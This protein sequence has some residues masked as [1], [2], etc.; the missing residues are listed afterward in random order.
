MTIKR[1]VCLLGGSAVGKTSLVTRFVRGAYDE[2]Y[3]TTVGV[4]I[5]T[6]AMKIDERS[7]NL[8]I[9]DLNGEDEFQS[10]QN[11]YLRGASGYFL[12]V[13][14]TR[15]GTLETVKELRRRVGEQLGER[16]F[17]L[18]LNK[19]DRKESWEIPAE[20]IH[21]LVEAGWEVRETSAKTG[22]GVLGAFEALGRKVIDLE[23]LT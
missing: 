9:W 12:V 10:L 2:T 1:K 18:L 5:D 19:S 3:L 16:P 21:A 15:P 13:D 14:G 11:S 8:V 6:Y 7:M 4:K 20:E 23:D 17:V 22:A